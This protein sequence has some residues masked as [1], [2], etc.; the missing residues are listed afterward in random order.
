MS[1]LVSPGVQVKELDLTNVVPA[2]AASKAGYAGAFN[3]GPIEAFVTVS[4]EKELAENYG[5]PT[6]ATTQ[7]FHT[8]ASFLKYGNDLKVVRAAG[9]GALNATSGQGASEGL[10]IKNREVYELGGLSQTVGVFAAKWAGTLGNNLGVSVCTSSTAFTNWFVNGTNSNDGLWSAYFDAAPGTSAFAANAGSANDEMH[11]VVFDATGLLT[12]TKY[13]VLEKFAFVSQAIDALKEDG[14]SN[15]YVNVLAANSKWIWQ[16]AHPTEANSGTGLSLA[17]AGTSVFA[18]ASFATET[19]QLDYAFGGGVDAAPTAGN[20]EDALNV[21]ADAE[22]VDVN[23]LFAQVDASGKTIAD[24]LIEIAEARK[25]CLALLSPPVSASTGADPANTVITWANTISST[26]YASIDSGALKVYD[27]YN[28]TY[29]W[30]PASG[31]VAGLC[32]KTDSQADAWFS[33]AGFNRGNLLGVTKL[34]YNPNQA[35]RDALYKARVNPLVSFPGQGIVLYGDKTALAKPSAFDRI[36][37]RRLF[38]VLEKSIATA[39]KYQ[40]FEF[41]DEF[42]QA[43]FRNMSEPFLRDVQGRRGITDFKV[44]CD[45]TN[46]TGDVIDRNEFRADIYVK[47]ARSINF[48]TLN[49]IATRTGVSFTE[50]VGK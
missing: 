50:L 20:V 32:A 33:P 12:G 34:A 14:T 35:A 16:L 2:T 15:Y 11:I 45:S 46:N 19:A 24:K 25:D 38:I 44:V 1:F 22:T 17:D 18:T 36:N 49:F 5:K 26:S 3:W 9:S 7:S 27:K 48:I 28:D 41:N 4:S 29:I 39:A 40:L 13:T 23:L 42:T 37:V 31:H 6:S 47:P 43:M 21:L 8:A 30:I 10:L